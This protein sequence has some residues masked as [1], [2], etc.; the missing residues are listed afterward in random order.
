MSL[1][2]TCRPLTTHLM[3][4]R[5]TMG[6]APL[7]LS[8]SNTPGI[9]RCVWFRRERDRSKPRHFFRVA[10]VEPYRN[11]SAQGA[12]Q[13]HQQY[14]HQQ[15]YGAYPHQAPAPKTQECQRTDT[16]RNQVNLKKPTL[17]LEKT[18]IPEVYQIVFK[19]DASAPC[20]WGR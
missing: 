3:V 7:R 9:S 13:Y 4:A 11:A 6:L 14:Q 15:A 2:M 1:L 16:I 20:R 12:H 18:A 19:F 17:K 10:R 5:R 8:S